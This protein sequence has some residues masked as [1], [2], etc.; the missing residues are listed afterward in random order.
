MRNSR[1]ALSTACRDGVNP[2][3][4]F[5]DPPGEAA[6]LG[7]VPLGQVEAAAAGRNWH[8]TCCEGMLNP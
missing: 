5:G 4:L 3:R 1:E 6:A 7:Q 8:E 2:T